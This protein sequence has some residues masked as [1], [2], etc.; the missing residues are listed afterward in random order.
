LASKPT[1]RGLGQ[2][3]RSLRSNPIISSRDMKAF[4]WR[5]QWFIFFTSDPQKNAWIQI[6]S[7]Q[8]HH[9]ARDL[10]YKIWEILSRKTKKT[11]DLNSEFFLFDL[12][13][14]FNESLCEEEK[15][16]HSK[17]SERSAI[18]RIFEKNGNHFRIKPTMKFDRMAKPKLRSEK[19]QNSYEF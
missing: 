14:K 11:T 1:R 9:R 7:D 8:I 19:I 15:V 17:F 6:K 13:A 4:C 16:D 2:T 18:K 5:L 3:T 10:L 12:L